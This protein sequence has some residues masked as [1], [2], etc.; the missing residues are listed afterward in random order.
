ML[1][2]KSLG[3]LNEFKGPYWDLRLHSQ[4]IKDFQKQSG[5]IMK[6]S[7]FR[8]NF[9]YASSVISC[10]T[11]WITRIHGM[12]PFSHMQSYGLGNSVFLHLTGEKKHLKVEE[13]PDS[14]HF[15]V[16]VSRFE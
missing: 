14:L 6:M 13:K 1:T 12:P 4:D 10:F 16:Q 11:T 15:L 2:C 5:I 8:C 3:L 7:V 9:N